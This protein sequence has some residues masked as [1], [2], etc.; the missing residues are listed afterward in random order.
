MKSRRYSTISD[1]P[2][3]LLCFLCHEGVQRW[4]ASKSAVNGTPF[5]D[6]C[7]NEIK[8]G[9]FTACLDKECRAVC[10]DHC[11]KLKYKKIHKKI[12]IKQ[13]T[14]NNN[15]NSIKHHQ[16]NQ[17]T[18]LMQ[19]NNNNTSNEFNHNDNP[20]IL[21]IEENDQKND[22][23]NLKSPAPSPPIF[24]EIEIDS[25]HLNSNGN[26]H[27]WPNNIMNLWMSTLSK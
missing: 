9:K 8:N 3:N 7:Q 22:E 16:I 6:V 10:C 18:N 13:E 20:F 5:C 24:K 14:N 26:F 19:H 25:N 12:Q 27:I 15:K 23:N 1:K 17:I 2:Q 11:F 4:H 21:Q